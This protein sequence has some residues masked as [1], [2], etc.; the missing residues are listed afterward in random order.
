MSSLETMLPRTCSLR[1]YEF[2]ESL[3][4]KKVEIDYAPFRAAAELLYAGPWVAE[5]LAAIQPFLEKH[6]G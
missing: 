4:G 1:R 3:G 6:G 2:L 5:R